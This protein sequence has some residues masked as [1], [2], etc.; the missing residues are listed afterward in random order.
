MNIYAI[1]IAIAVSS[2][3]LMLTS[4]ETIQKENPMGTMEDRA[5]RSAGGG[6]NSE[7]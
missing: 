3:V 2:L 5:D 7:G 6:G 1:H 4:C